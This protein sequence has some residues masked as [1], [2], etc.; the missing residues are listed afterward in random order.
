MRCSLEIHK[1]A[2]MTVA[3][4]IHG[5]TANIILSGNV[6]YSM[7]DEIQDANQSALSNKQVIE[8]CVD[9]AASV[10]M[11]RPIFTTIMNCDCYL[12]QGIEYSM[13]RW[14]LLLLWTR[15]GFGIPGK[16]QINGIEAAVQ[17]SSFRH[18][19]KSCLMPLTGFR[20]MTG[21]FMFA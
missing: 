13:E 17:G 11:G 12:M 14:G 3:V 9:F 5:T 10:F 20:Q 16:T 8:I 19:T 15:E 1:E 6:D 2:G 18:L 4:D 7:Q 21:S